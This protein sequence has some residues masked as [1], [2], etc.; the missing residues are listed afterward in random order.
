MNALERMR[1]AAREEEE[2]KNSKTKTNTVKGPSAY[3]PMGDIPDN[4]ISIFRFLPDGNPDNVN[5]WRERQVCKLVFDGI[6]GGDY[7]T[8]E[9]VEVTVPCMDMFVEPKKGVSLCPVI[10]GTKHLWKDENDTIKIELARQYY[11]KRSFMYQGFVV[12]TDVEEDEVPENPIRLFTIYPSVQKVIKSVVT[13]TE[14]EDIPT[15]YL[16]GRDFRY[17]KDK[18]PSDKWP[19]YH[20][21]KWSSKVRP[22]SEEET[23]AV[24]KYDLIDLNTLLGEQPDAEGIA[25]I[26]AM[27]KD[28][29]AGKPFDFDSYGTHYR[30]FKVNGKRADPEAISAVSNNSERVSA[31]KRD[32]VSEVKEE[33]AKTA[34]NPSDIL[35]KLREKHSKKA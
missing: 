1:Q 13:D 33:S 17:K 22:L 16:L 26:A 21:S 29:F 12:S 3:F 24:Q 15:D 23:I 11:K 6:V 25:I 14:I 20:G 32:E 10:Q 28:S 18:T 9:T 5:F 31:T 8:D 30:A 27:F 35:S 2:R 4:T 19:Q 34:S 7:P